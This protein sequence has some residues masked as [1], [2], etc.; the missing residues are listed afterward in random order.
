[1]INGIGELDNLLLLL[2]I[3]MDGAWYDGFTLKA[4]KSWRSYG[5]GIQHGNYPGLRKCWEILLLASFLLKKS[6][7]K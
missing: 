5:R 1:M 3:F 4:G 7:T 2:L 6:W